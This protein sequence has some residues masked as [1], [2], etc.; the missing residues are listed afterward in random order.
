M[1][2]NENRGHI[3]DTFSAYIVLAI[4]K[5]KLCTTEKNTILR[6]MLDTQS[7]KQSTVQLFCLKAARFLR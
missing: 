3:F 7:D 4:R 5:R 1:H 6:A 2:I